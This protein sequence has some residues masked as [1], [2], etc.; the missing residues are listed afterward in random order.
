[1]GITTSPHRP[2][3][4]DRIHDDLAGSLGRDAVLTPKTFETDVSSG[5][6][7][8]HL[9]NPTDGLRIDLEQMRRPRLPTKSGGCIPC[10]VGVAAIPSF[11]PIGDPLAQTA[12]VYLGAMRRAHHLIPVVRVARE[13]TPVAHNQSYASRVESVFNELEEAAQVALPPV[14]VARQEHVEL[15]RSGGRKHLRHLRMP[16]HSPAGLGYLPAQSGVAQAIALGESVH[17]LALA[18]RS[19][20]VELL[21]CRLA[22]PSSR[23]KATEVVQ[24]TGKRP[25]YHALITSIRAL[26][27]AS[28]ASTPLPP[29]TARSS[30]RGD[31]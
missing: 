29:R 1:M 18:I 8:E 22:H 21:V 26:L 24:R 16:P 11:I 25:A 12:A 9:H 31:E 4:V 7:L 5:V 2:A 19:V 14:G 17:L 30:L 6:P 10:R 3:V 27:F 20:T 23:A 13:Q 15:A 28:Y